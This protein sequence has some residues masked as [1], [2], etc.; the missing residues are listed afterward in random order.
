[1]SIDQFILFVP[2]FCNFLR[3]FTVFANLNSSIDR[4]MDSDLFLWISLRNIMRNNVESILNHVSQT[5]R[6]AHF[7]K[8]IIN[9]TQINLS[10]TISFH[11]LQNTSILHFSINSTISSWS[12]G[13]LSFLFNHN[14][15]VIA[16]SRN[17]TLREENNRLWMVTEIVV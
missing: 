8:N 17:T 11:M 6:I 9:W 3:Y 15:S 5:Q 12:Q 10:Y 4:Y 13:Y 7:E 2:H 16:D 14:L 1:M